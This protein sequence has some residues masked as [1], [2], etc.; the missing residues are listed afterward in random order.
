MSTSPRSMRRGAIWAI[1]AVFA[2]I[3]VILTALP[4]IS[5]ASIPADAAPAS[6]RP[7][8]PAVESN[9]WTQVFTAPQIEPGIPFHFYGMTFVNQQIG[10]AYGGPDWT[11][12]VFS[13][14]G[15]VYKTTDAGQTWTLVHESPGWKI[16]MA[17]WDAMHCWVGGKWGRVYYTEDG[18]S[19]WKPATTYTWAEPVGPTPTP[20][21]FTAW[22]RSGA[23]YPGAGSPI[24]FGAGEQE[25]G[26]VILRSTDGWRFYPSIPLLTQYRVATWSMDCPTSTICYGGQIKKLIV[27]TTDGGGTWNY[28]ATTS[29]PWTCH[30]ELPE[31]IQ[32]RYYGLDFVNQNWGWAVG[33]C[34][35]IFRT[36]NGG[37]GWQAQNANISVDV[38]FRAVRMFD[39]SNG[40]A[41]GGENPDLVNDPTLAQSAVIYATTNGVNWLPVAAP[42]TDELHGVGA[43]GMSGIV[44]AD[45]A[46]N[47]WRKTGPIQDITPTP[48][49]TAQPT[50]TGT[51]TPTAS[52]TPTASLT[53]TPT[54]TSSP[55]LTPTPSSTP[56]T[57]VL[58]PRAFAD[59]NGDGL[60]APGDPLL[61]GAQLEL[62]NASQVVDNCITGANGVC[63]FADLTPGLYTLASKA[64]PPGYTSVVSTLTVFV[65]AGATV[66]IDLPYI[67]A[68]STPTETP[69]PTVTLAA[70]RVWLP[71]VV[72]E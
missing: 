31:P 69:S 22:I 41:V 42:Q 71:I 16:S 64:P 49:T 61:E 34:G 2:M 18:G 54:T 65:Q 25:T 33:S 70:R 23:T 46:G 5:Q 53:P 67:A 15:R 39:N 14:P 45:W 32:Q 59:S 56:A 9:G 29:A 30:D 68:T 10:F 35:A 11:A 62:R 1:L 26:G 4:A 58:R 12:G 27:K 60:Y 21:P 20:V 38:Q 52:V 6:S 17:C 24:F 8:A 19:T 40:V 48:S 7:A 37:L 47:I 36:N 50:T 44:V 3:A 28:T 66:E 57:G 72:R 63:Q 51:S 43:F 13:T 55:S